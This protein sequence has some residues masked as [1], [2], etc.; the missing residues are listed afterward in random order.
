MTSQSEP[1]P[2]GL[3]VEFHKL[4][5]A[6]IVSNLGD[7]IGVVWGSL[8]TA[9]RQE[10]TPAELRGRVSGAYRFIAIGSAA[11]GALLGGALASRFGLL[12][13]FWLHALVGVAI[14]PLVWSTFSD[15]SVAAARNSPPRSHDPC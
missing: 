2:R 15:A 8:V 14:I 10:L 13:P 5:A 1:A 3:G 4:W 6:S 11:P 7:A 9:L 12:A